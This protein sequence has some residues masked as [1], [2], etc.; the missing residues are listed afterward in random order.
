VRADDIGRIT[1]IVGCLA[2]VLLGVVVL[3]AAT[4]PRSAGIAIPATPG[5]TTTA[6]P[7]T[8]LDLNN[9][10][11]ADFVI[12]GSDLVAVP[13]SPPSDNPWTSY[14]VPLSSALLGVLGGIGAA[15]IGRNKGAYR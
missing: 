2:A 1:R 5:I 10:G 15:V 9:D 11:K 7:V 8:V 3:V 14:G 12:Y 6:P 13:Q 4:R